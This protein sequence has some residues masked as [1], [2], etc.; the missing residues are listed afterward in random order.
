MTHLKTP[1]PLWPTLAA[2]TAAA[3]AAG[4]AQAQQDLP[5]KAP[6][7]TLEEEMPLSPRILNRIRARE[8]FDDLLIYSGENCPEVTLILTEGATASIPG[9][10]SATGAAGGPGDGLRRVGL[11]SLDE[12]MPL[13][14]RILNRIRAREDFD[15]LL[16]YS[17]ANCPE[18]GL[19]L[20]EGATAAIPA[21]GPATGPATGAATQGPDGG[22]RTVGLCSLEE[23]MP[24]PR[25]VLNRIVAR[26]DYEDLL[27]YA[28]DNCPE[29]ALL[30]T[31]TATATVPGN[32]EGGGT[33]DNGVDREGPED[34]NP[35]TG[36]GGEGPTD[37][38]PT[39]PGPTDP[40]PTDPGPT[41]PGPTDPGPTDPGPTDPG[42]DVSDGDDDPNPIGDNTGGA[43][44][45][46]A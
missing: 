2:A 39:D 22:A 17:G 36:G 9:T 42:G 5:R 41:D 25:R 34:R 46:E 6:L 7:C 44:E 29:V 35:Q 33:L 14:P 16:R 38:G 30:L 19:I 45:E 20:T 13:S 10:G 8:D 27:L 24:L 1:R 28:S 18:V 4:A 31:D 26:A 21:A 12:E 37:P 43:G 11:C 3:L 23:E 32:G 15:D 40:G